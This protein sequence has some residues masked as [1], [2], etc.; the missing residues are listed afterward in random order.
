MSFFRDLPVDPPTNPM[1]CYGASFY[2]PCTEL[3]ASKRPTSLLTLW[4]NHRF[5]RLAMAVTIWNRDP[6]N[7]TSI[8]R[9][10]NL[11]WT[12]RSKAETDLA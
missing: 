1:L 6:A 2:L 4:S 5:A 7:R 9:E 8:K 3:V 10:Q 11:K 12:E